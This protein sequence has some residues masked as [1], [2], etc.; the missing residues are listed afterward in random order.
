[1]SAAPLICVYV[2]PVTGIKCCNQIKN[3]RK[4]IETCIEHTPLKIRLPT[5]PMPLHL[6]TILVKGIYFYTDKFGQIY[7]TE[8]VVRKLPNPRIVP[9]RWKKLE[10]GEIIMYGLE[11]GH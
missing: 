5:D 6:N 4:N 1:M 3:P 8:D 7:N 9:G 11:E 2:N 10:D